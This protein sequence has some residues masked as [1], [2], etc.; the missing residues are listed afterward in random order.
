MTVLRTLDSDW[1]L[2][3]LSLGECFNL[4]EPQFLICEWG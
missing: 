1:N 3:S 4:S 2:P